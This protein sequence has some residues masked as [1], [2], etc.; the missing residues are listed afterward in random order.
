MRED[1]HGEKQQHSRGNEMSTPRAAV[2]ACTRITEGDQF[3]L[4]VSI[5]TDRQTTP[6]TPIAQVGE[7]EKLLV[8]MGTGM[9]GKPLVI[10]THSGCAVALS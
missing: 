10:H 1:E 5:A 6:P 2:P 4:L 8:A 3:S 7:V 9:G